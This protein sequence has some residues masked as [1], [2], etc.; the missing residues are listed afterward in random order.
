MVSHEI[1]FPR[2][3]VDEGSAGDAADPDLLTEGEH[4]FGRTTALVLR[5]RPGG[6]YDAALVDRET[7]AERPV[8]LRPSISSAWLNVAHLDEWGERRNNSCVWVTEG[9]PLPGTPAWGAWFRAQTPGCEC[10]HEPPRHCV[11]HC[12][13]R[14]ER[15]SCL[16]CVPSTTT[17]VEAAP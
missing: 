5:V 14:D 1:V 12:G 6:G 4:D 15:C 17:D 16:G 2:Q 13:P 3:D 10:H 8:E 7:G 9:E 11:P